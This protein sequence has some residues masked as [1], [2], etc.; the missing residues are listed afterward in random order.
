M[1]GRPPLSMQR[2]HWRLTAT[3]LAGLAA[4]ALAACGTPTA[5]TDSPVRLVDVVP[6]GATIVHPAPPGPQTSSCTTSLAPPTTMPSPGHM[7][8]GSYMAQIQTRGYLRVGVD[9]NTYLWGYRDPVSG[10]LDGFDIAMLRQVSQAIFGSP[11]RID[12]VIVRNADRL[13]AVTSGDVDILAETM[14]VNCDREKSVDFSSVYFEAGQ[15]I[16]VPDNSSITGPQ[17]LGGKR[18]CAPAASTSLQNLVKPGMPRHIQIWAVNNETDCLVMLQQHQVDAISTDDGILFGLAAQDPTTEIVGPTFSS[19]P[20]GMA[21]SKK[22]P[23]FTSFVNGVLAQVSVDG[24]W[25]QIY[26]QYLLPHIP[27]PAPAPPT[28]SYG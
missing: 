18:V 27:G 14:T 28:V 16:L 4:C 3:A 13:R 6:K 9:Q 15:R 17:D 25:T 7:P 21:I 19:E 8:A 23:D 11:D 1:S 22:H 24:T 12:P 26:D 5:A 10:Q 20:Y 2:R